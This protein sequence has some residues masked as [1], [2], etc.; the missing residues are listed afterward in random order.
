MSDDEDDTKRVVRSAKEKRNEQ[1]TQLIKSIRNS[2]K[3]KDFNKMETSFVE[4]TKAYEK[5]KATILKEE[6]GATPRYYVRILVEMEDLINETWEDKEFRKA[7]SKI[8]SKSL[9]ALRQKLRKYIR[10][11]WEQKCKQTFTTLHH[12][13]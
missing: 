7:M 3:I 10:S 4:L 5:A 2:K 6:S 13:N 11:G 12:L 9:S 8:N 1:M